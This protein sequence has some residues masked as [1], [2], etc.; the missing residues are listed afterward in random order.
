MNQN[1]GQPAATGQRRAVP[2][3]DDL[4]T[5]QNEQ[6]DEILR[7]SQETEA[8]GAIT[9]HKLKVQGERIKETA[10]KIDSTDK[11]LKTSE[12]LIKRLRKKWWFF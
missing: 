10:G 2:T 5:Q 12:S 3:A 6:L 11:E 7:M 1:D 4:L 8:I 9:I